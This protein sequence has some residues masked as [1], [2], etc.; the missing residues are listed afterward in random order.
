MI[1][2]IHLVQADDV[3][4]PLSTSLSKE[5]LSTSSKRIICSDPVLGKYSDPKGNSDYPG[6]ITYPR[7]D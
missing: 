4:A 7:S 5:L 1:N 2:P 3:L 6:L